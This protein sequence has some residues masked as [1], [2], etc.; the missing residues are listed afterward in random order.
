MGGRVRSP[1]PACL[2]G[3]PLLAVL[4]AGC[5]GQSCD[6]SRNRDIFT[7]TGCVVGGGYGQRAD[8]LETQ[9][10][11]AA[12][13][14]DAAQ[15]ALAAAAGRRDRLAEDEARL[16]GE[17]ADQRLQAIDLQRRVAAAQAGQ[18]ANREQLRQMQEDIAVLRQRQEAL[19]SQSLPPAVLRQQIQELENQREA[20][21][22][23][24]RQLVEAIPRA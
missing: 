19:R 7:V 21:Q 18:R 5:S 24:Y 2:S 13:D 11:Q 4:L 20:L 17:L 9:A 14:R 3:L 12:A 1:L 10:A 16:R 15:V 6:P 8:A 23:R 22:R